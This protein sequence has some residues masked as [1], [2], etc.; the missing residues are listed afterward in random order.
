MKWLR[1]GHELDRFAESLIQMKNLYIFGIGGNAQEML[2]MISG[3]AE[4][5]PCELVLIDSNEEKQRG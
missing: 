2:L 4:P 3:I 5:L 1:K